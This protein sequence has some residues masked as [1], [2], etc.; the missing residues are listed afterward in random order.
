MSDEWAFIA[1][2]R[3]ARSWSLSELAKRSGVAKSL[4][5]KLERGEGNPRIATLGKI[6][7]AFDVALVVRFVQGPPPDRKD[8]CP[9][10]RYECIR[11]Q[12]AWWG[13][14]P[15][16]PDAPVPSFAEE[17]THREARP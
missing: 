2:H 8:L 13:K 11:A 14:C 10:F 9:L 17:N 3:K 1:Q 4:I 15:R 5:W 7:A 6:A 12:C 16:I